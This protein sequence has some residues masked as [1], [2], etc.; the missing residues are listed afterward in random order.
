MVKKIL[1]LTFA[2]SILLL[3]SIAFAALEQSPTASAAATSPASALQIPG[4]PPINL[5]SS[6][7]A[8]LLMGLFGAVQAVVIGWIKSRDPV[9]GKLSAFDWTMAIETLG[10][11]L[12][13][14]LV[15]H[16][17]KWAPQ[18]LASWLQATPMG[19][20]IITGVESLLNLILRHSVPALKG[21]ITLWQTS[22]T[23]PA[24]PP[25]PATKPQ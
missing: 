1:A 2:L 16:F 21:V 8:G 9:T 19:G 17:L 5:G 7:W 13:I 24:N 20:A 10:V 12:I 6:W 18:D 15:A 14:G 25:P 4:L 23:T 3:P 22:Q 11:G